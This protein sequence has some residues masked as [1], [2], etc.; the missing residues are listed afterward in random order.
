MLLI[1]LSVHLEKR[2]KALIAPR[3]LV[4][5]ARVLCRSAV[6]RRPLVIARK[7]TCRAMLGQA[8]DQYVLQLAQITMPENKPVQCLVVDKARGL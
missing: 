7:C 6:T 2:I 8:F 5:L 3:V 4:H 1:Q